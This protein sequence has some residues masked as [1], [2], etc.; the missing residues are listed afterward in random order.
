MSVEVEILTHTLDMVDILIVDRYEADAE[1]IAYVD[2]HGVQ[3]LA[4]SVAGK[5]VLE[6]IASAVVALSSMACILVR[7]DCMRRRRFITHH[8][9]QR[10]KHDEEVEILGKQLMQVPGPMYLY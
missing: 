3:P 9:S 10:T 2:R 4:S 6:N 8:S 5:I 1:Q 7:R